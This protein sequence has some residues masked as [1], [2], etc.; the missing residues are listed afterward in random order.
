MCLF[1]TPRP[2]IIA[3]F[4]HKSAYRTA[5]PIY[6]P[7]IYLSLMLQTSTAVGPSK[8][9]L[10]CLFGRRHCETGI[11]KFLSL[12]LKLRLLLLP[13]CWVIK[14]ILRADFIRWSVS[15]LGL[16]IRSLYLTPHLLAVYIC[17]TGVDAGAL[18][19][20][21]I[22]ILFIKILVNSNKF[23]IQQ[24]TYSFWDRGSTVVKVPCYKSEG[25][26]FDPSWCHWIFHWH[27]ILPIALWPWGRLS[28]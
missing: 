26:W 7:A 3:Q 18:Y 2:D 8:C 21:L 11:L 25:R 19:G 28:L 14:N 22:I 16:N 9:T 1:Q 6:F 5:S 15:G 20:P 17:S 12:Y 27:K 4:L 10:C 24:S 23:T 13:S